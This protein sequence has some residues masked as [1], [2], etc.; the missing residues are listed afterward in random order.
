MFRGTSANPDVKVVAFNDPFMPLDYMVNHDLYVEL[1]VVIWAACPAGSCHF[2]ATAT[3]ILCT[4]TVHATHSHTH[5]PGGSGLGSHVARRT[6]GR[7][8]CGTLERL[9]TSARK[10]RRGL[11]VV[12]GTTGYYL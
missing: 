12:T 5:V 10:E 11:P 2:H 3:H 7:T 6:T 4:Y 8:S 1:S 9:R